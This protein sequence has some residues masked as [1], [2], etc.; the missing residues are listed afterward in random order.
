MTLLVR[1]NGLTK[2]FGYHLAV[3]HLNFAV[4]E[5]EVFGLLGPNGAGK[6][7]TIRMLSCLIAPSEGEAVVAGYTIADNPLG[8]RK[9][10][11]I[12]TENPS[13]YER[14]SAQ[15]NLNFFAEAYDLSKPGE[16][17]S[18]I[19]ELLEFFEASCHLIALI[20]AERGWAGYRL[21]CTAF[22]WCCLRCLRSRRSSRRRPLLR[23]TCIRGRAAGNRFW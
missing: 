4:E 20:S 12:L 8:V 16:K 23:R 2:V 6:T 14:L 1:A 3:D 17:T 22:C 9:T 7:T 11:G 5:G 21:R 10:V 19:R 15:E 13:L 18:R